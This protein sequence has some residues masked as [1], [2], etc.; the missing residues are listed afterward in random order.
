MILSK[1]KNAELL[2]TV[3]KL[4]HQDRKNQVELLWHLLEIQKRR[5]YLDLGYPSL[6][7]YVVTELG[8]GH[9]SAYRRIQA[10]RL[11]EAVPS[12]AI[13]IEDGRINLSTAAQ[14]QNFLKAEKR[15]GTPV[16]SEVKEQMVESIENKSAREVERQLIA[17]KPESALSGEKIRYVT[18]EIVEI[19]LI[20]PD[21]LKNKL[22]ALKLRFSHSVDNM[23]YIGL[24]EFL[25][26]KALI[27]LDRKAQ[28]AAQKL[29]PSSGAP[30]EG[31]PLRGR[32]IS[33]VLRHAVR[34]R[35]Q[36][37]SSFIDPKSGRRCAG[38]YQLQIDHVIPYSK[39]G[40]NTLENLRLLCGEH[41]RKKGSKSLP[42][43]TKNVT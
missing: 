41:N 16:S 19:K 22:D 35:D 10:M 23:T 20:V 25:A 13:K 17:L 14:V 37:C 27:T 28:A 43:N 12:V 9:S 32:H 40:L 1:L 34:M 39:G 26:D 7:E 18:P 31:A 29:S 11:L 36:G 5:L 24:I 3:K 33:S 6:F 8:Y 38:K 21:A 4:A 30:S 2:E 15:S 42:E